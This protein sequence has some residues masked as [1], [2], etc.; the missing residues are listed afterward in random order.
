M[1]YSER[2]EGRND[3]GITPRVLSKDKMLKVKRSDRLLHMKVL[4][5][6]DYY[7]LSRREEGIL[8]RAGNIYIERII[9]K[10]KV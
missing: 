6:K 5:K 4:K 2:V 3:I 10:T 9:N 1:C 7:C 8:T